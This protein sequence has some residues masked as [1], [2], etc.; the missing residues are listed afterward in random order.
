VLTAAKRQVWGG[1]PLGYRMVAD[2]GDQFCDL[3]GDH[4]QGA[5]TLPKPMY[6]IP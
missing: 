6:F 3:Q 1:R 4:E 2:V 5:F